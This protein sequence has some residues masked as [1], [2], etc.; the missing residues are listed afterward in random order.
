[1]AEERDGI[2]RSL[3]AA[4][5][6]CDWQEAIVALRRLSYFPITFYAHLAQ[7]LKHAFKEADSWTLH[8]LILCVTSLVRLEQNC[9]LAGLARGGPYYVAVA[10][11]WTA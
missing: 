5:K 2:V 11:T 3:V 10:T 9:P 8:G 6:L 4:A 7:L 1:M